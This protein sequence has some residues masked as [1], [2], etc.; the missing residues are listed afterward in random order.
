MS[1]RLVLIRIVSKPGFFNSYAKTAS[2]FLATRSL[3]RRFGIPFEVDLYLLEAD[4]RALAVAAPECPVVTVVPT[5][6]PDSTS[7]VLEVF[8][9]ELE[10]ITL[11]S[12]FFRMAFVTCDPSS[13]SSN[14]ELTSSPNTD[15][16]R[17][18]KLAGS[19]AHHLPEQNMNIQNTV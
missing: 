5:G 12:E 14:R 18:G 9:L 17:S 3:R 13:T 16:W 2:L 15:R 8:F 10:E 19:N 6:N 7:A 1:Q 11:A 4:D